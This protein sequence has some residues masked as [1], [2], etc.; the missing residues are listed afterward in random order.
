M[1]D[2]VIKSVENNIDIIVVITL[3]LLI[4]IIEI[5]IPIFCP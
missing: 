3:G 4:T 5:Y 2:M 1:H